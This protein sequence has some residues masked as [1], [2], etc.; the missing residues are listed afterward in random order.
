GNL[1]FIKKNIGRLVDDAITYLQEVIGTTSGVTPRPLMLDNEN[2]NKLKSNLNP[3]DWQHLRSG[4]SSMVIRASLK[5]EVHYTSI[6]SGHLL[7]C[8]SSTLQQSIRDVNAEGGVWPG[9]DVKI[10]ATPEVMIK[11]SKDALG[12]VLKIQDVK[13]WPHLT[14]V[15]FSV[16]GHDSTLRSSTD[17][18]GILNGLRTLSLVIGGLW[19]KSNDI[20]FGEIKNPTIAISDLKD[21]TLDDLDVIRQYRPIALSITKTPEQEDEDR[22]ISIIHQNPSVVSLIIGCHLGRY[23]ALINRLKSTIEGMKRNG[24]QPSISSF[25]LVDPTLLDSVREAALHDGVRLEFISQQLLNSEDIVN[26]D[27]YN[28]SSSVDIQTHL[29][30]N[31]F[32]SDGP[33]VYDFIRQFGYSIVTLVVQG[34]FSDHLA[35]LLD[36]STK[37][38]SNI[39]RLDIAPTS[40]TK[41]GLDAMD[42]IIK[43][44]TELTYLRLTLRSLHQ[45]QQL[46]K[47]LLL[48]EQ[49]KNRVTS[50]HVSLWCEESCLTKIKRVLPDRSRF[51][52]LEEFS[53]DCINWD[54]GP[55]GTAR[56]WIISMISARAQPPTP[57]LKVVGVK[58][59]LQPQDWEAVIKAIDL[60]T[61]EELHFDNCNF[62]QEQ[63]KL[64]ADRV[65]SSYVFLPLKLLDLKGSEVEKAA[66][67]DAN[68]QVIFATVQLKAPQVRIEGQHNLLY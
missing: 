16:K 24:G 34:S 32:K 33:A 12:K 13:R 63:L 56:Q 5:K 25:K 46:E 10:M 23:A 8:Y 2:L 17:I 53:V 4:L 26:V 36:E 59:D 45:E 51:P 44:S 38:V 7:D 35:K 62:S 43:R 1:R 6:C 47:A 61:L 68:T 22:L 11:L 65:W 18:F 55:R 40:L 58:I 42:R 30:S 57:P 39:A 67:D 64:L 48:L 41:A 37:P 9:V 52:R 31:Q 28:G 50:V 21:L 54:R 27:I 15:T 60:S 29:R 20:S 19:M 14:R 49:Y 3:K 66:G